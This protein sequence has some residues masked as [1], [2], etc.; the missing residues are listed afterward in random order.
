MLFFF[1]ISSCK[2]EL[3][4]HVESSAIKDKTIEWMISKKTNASPLEAAAMD[5]VINNLNW[6]MVYT[7]Q[8][9]DSLT[10]AFISINSNADKRLTILY[11]T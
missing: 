5:S 3:N 6:D 7:D 2:K 4:T 11:N 8:I 9:N 1:I 10:T